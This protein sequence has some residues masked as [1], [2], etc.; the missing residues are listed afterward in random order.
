MSF[1]S[2]V[3][4]VQTEDEGRPAGGGDL[5]GGGG[6]RRTG[7]TVRLFLIYFQLGTLRLDQLAQAAAAAQNRGC[8]GP[9]GCL[10]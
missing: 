3:A 6:H 9:G 7:Y 5:S 10:P 4:V 1:T 8:F 2:Y